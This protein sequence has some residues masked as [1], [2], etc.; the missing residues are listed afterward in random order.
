[1]LRPGGR[2][3][4]D[5][6]MAPEDAELAEFM[7]RFEQWRDP[8][9]V[10]AHSIAE[11]SAWIEAAGLRIEHVDPL[12]LKRYDFDSWAERMRMPAA[13]RAAL[14]AWLIAAPARC[15]EFFEL[16]VADGRV[17]SICGAFAIIVARKA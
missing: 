15:R 8:S 12:V 1:M 9:H 13:E 5:D 3:V 7:N 2:L 17:Q 6:N 14:E 11:W 10:R 4:L 16:V